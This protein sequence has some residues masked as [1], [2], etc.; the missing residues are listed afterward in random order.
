MQHLSTSKRIGLFLGPLAF[1]LFWKGIHLE[2]LS[3]E[4]HA[5][6]AS[7]LWVA[8]WW[9]TEALP[10]AITSLLPIALF[11]LTGGM[12]IADTTASFGHQYIFLYIGGFI[13]AIAIERWHLHKRIAL[14][15]ILLI[16]TN[17]KRIVLGFM[18]A[19]AFL[20]M[21]ISNTATSVMM[22]PIG[23]AIVS[24]FKE[25]PGGNQADSATF[26]KMLML[27]IAYSASIGGVATLI[28]TPPNLV[29]ASVLREEY[30]IEITF[31]QWIM[32]GLPVSTILL[33]VCWKYLTSFAFKLQLAGFPGGQEAIREQLT[34]MGKITYE[35][36][37]VLR[38]FVLTALAWISRSFLLQRINP[39]IDDTIIAL[40]A[41]V[42]LFILPAS[43]DKKRALITW[44]EAVK[45][46]W[47]IL[48]LFGG[49]LA[50]AKGFSDTGLA[51]W[52]GSQMSLLQGVSL[53]VLLMTLVAMVNF[54]T[55][56]TSNLATTAM[57]LPILAP[58]ALAMD[59]HPYILMV[60][61][62][63]AASC[64]FM[65]PVATPPNAVVF[66][67]GYLKI[68]DMVRTGIWMN[69]ISILIL[70]A[71]IYLLLPVLWGFDP[72]HFP[73]EFAQD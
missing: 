41:G 20:S 66:G 37:I 52:I 70:T 26:G 68:Y 50:L 8:I 53:L 15:L 56:I 14:N 24:Q 23:M 35:E 10:I 46:P 16:G 28:G 36:K 51:V 5:V 61:A 17:M 6:L 21:W 1:L 63:V 40:F 9:I 54:T 18:V 11:P 64:A 25:H 4:G 22:I 39:A 7:T 71:L 33:A 59:V 34:A 65:L 32:F 3:P 72:M 27:A 69:L 44:Q 19:T 48:L 42:A 57:M 12:S 45:L 30:D 43:R 58:F 2:G 73:Q 49:G 29:L 60:G 67:S 62:T 47:G 13:L 31:A 38:V 55:E